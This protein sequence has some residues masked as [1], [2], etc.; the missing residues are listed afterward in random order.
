MWASGS[1]CKSRETFQE[2]YVGQ[3]VWACPCVV[4][5]FPGAMV[6]SPDWCASHSPGFWGVRTWALEKSQIWRA[7]VQREWPLACEAQ[8][9]SK[10]QLGAHRARRPEC[11]EEEMAFGPGLY[12][13]ASGCICTPVGC[14]T[15]HRSQRI[16]GWGFSSGPRGYS[17][18]S[19]TPS[20]LLTPRSLLVS[21]LEAYPSPMSTFWL[22]LWFPWK[23]P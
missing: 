16:R 17:G 8:V 20:A 5:G 22:G 12:C 15:E 9:K 21:I 2:N 3:W 4:H 6:L 11:A 23:K 10:E 7:E 18:L 19:Y 14:S 13:M 1:R